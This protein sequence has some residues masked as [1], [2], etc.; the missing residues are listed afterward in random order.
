MEYLTE[1]TV[2]MAAQRPALFLHVPL[3]VFVVECLFGLILY[4]IVGLWVLAL[5]PLHF[6]FVAMTNQDFVWPQKLWATV[7]LHWLP[8]NRGVK[9]KGVVTFVPNPVNKEG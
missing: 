6:W 3:T 7:W 9:R 1:S 5:L 8:N 2:I 4:I